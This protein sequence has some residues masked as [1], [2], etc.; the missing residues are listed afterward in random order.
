MG[1]NRVT[2]LGVNF[3]EDVLQR[4]RHLDTGPDGETQAVGLAVAMVGILAEND[5]LYLLQRGMGKG[6][7]HLAAG[8]K[9][10][11]SRL[12]FRQ[13]KSA[14]SRH[15]GLLKLRRQLRQPAALQLHCP[16]HRPA[17]PAQLQAAI[18]M[19]CS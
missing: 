16:A 10:L 8:G 2:Q 7:E 3:L 13:Q 5:D 17:A 14:Q 6:V 1:G 4:R 19:T 15:V 12:F 11:F 18:S 9:E